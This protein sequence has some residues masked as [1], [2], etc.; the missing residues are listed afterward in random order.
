MIVISGKKRSG[1]DTV[2][3]FIAEA[4][5]RKF[6]LAAPIKEILLKAFRANGVT[7]TEDMLN[8]IDYDRETVMLLTRERSY[9]ILMDAYNIA[10]TMY[11]SKRY[12]DQFDYLI[13]STVK[14]K[15]YDSS[16]G[17]TMSVR[18]FMQFF[19]TDMMCQ[20]VSKY[21]WINYA[22][23]IGYGQSGDVLVDCRQPWEEEYYRN[24]DATFI[25]VKGAYSG[26]IEP[27]DNHI[28]EQGLTPRDGDI[29][30]V[31]E[32]ILTLAKETKCLLK[33]LMN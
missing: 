9:T 10:M 8:G 26:Y 27:T 31:N 13:K 33:K 11:T 32:N 19:G 1:K 16:Y 7:M 28:T 20:I 15:V 2:A 5:Y 3:N 23:D 4:G 24:K 17:D 12:G 6:S 25:F 14:S 18:K 21:F 22:T 30:L 29:I